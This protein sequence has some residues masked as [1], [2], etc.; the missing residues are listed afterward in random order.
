MKIFLNSKFRLS[1]EPFL[2]IIKQFNF[3]AEIIEIDNHQI[4][5]ID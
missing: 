2:L 1:S 4:K 5:I 3:D